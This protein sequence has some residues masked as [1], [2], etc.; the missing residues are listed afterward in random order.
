MSFDKRK[1]MKKNVE[2][3]EDAKLIPSFSNQAIRIEQR[4][5]YW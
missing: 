5:Q 3:L 2:N 4:H 1:A